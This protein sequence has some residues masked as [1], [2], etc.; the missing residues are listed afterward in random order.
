MPIHVHDPTFLACHKR[1]WELIK[2][3]YKLC[4]KRLACIYI[5]IISF[6]K[7]NMSKFMS[8]YNR[9]RN[10]ALNSTYNNIT[11]T[12]RSG[13]FHWCWKP[14]YPVTTTDCSQVT[15]KLHHIMLYH[16]YLTMSGIRTR[17][18]SGERH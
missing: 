5:K 11:V 8:T 9:V 13:Q 6:V 18:A 12:Y 2:I 4:S 16:V 17:N 14:E 7:N 15:G 1:L 3:Y 10:V